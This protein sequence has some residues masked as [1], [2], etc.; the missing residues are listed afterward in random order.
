MRYVH[1]RK[2]A[3][4]ACPE[5]KYPTYK[6]Y[7]AYGAVLPLCDSL[8]SIRLLPSSTSDNIRLLHYSFL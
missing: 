1:A 4:H 2:I 8:V 6:L 5:T 7:R 3:K